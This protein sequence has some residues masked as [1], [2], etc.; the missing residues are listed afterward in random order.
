MIIF[1]LSMRIDEDNEKI[2]RRRKDVKNEY[3]KRYN[4]KI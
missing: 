3:K 1:I 4:K 2:R